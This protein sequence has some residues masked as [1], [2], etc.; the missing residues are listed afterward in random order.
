[1][2][3]TLNTIDH[4]A[5]CYSLNGIANY[6][7]CNPTLRA[8]GGD[9]GGGGEGL[10]VYDKLQCGLQ[11]SVSEQRKERNLAIKEPGVA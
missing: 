5:V 8:T 11:K 3:Y 7:E 1:M 6:K 4:H 2:S 9:T 10:I